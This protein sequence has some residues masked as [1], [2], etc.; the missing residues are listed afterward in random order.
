VEGGRRQSHKEKGFF[1]IASR[2]CSV[3][4]K[5][6]RRHDRVT[7]GREKGGWGGVWMKVRVRDDM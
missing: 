2:S 1:L 6:K 4:E 7:M 5:G 3:I